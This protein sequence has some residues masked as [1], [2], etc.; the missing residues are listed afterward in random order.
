LDQHPAP[1]TSKAATRPWQGRSW[2]IGQLLFAIVGL[3]LIPFVIFAALA[4]A[5][6]SNRYQAELRRS[7][8]DLSRA[9]AIA[10]HG[11]LEASVH[12]IR[13]Y[14]ES[15]D[16]DAAD[17]RTLYEIA[18]RILLQRPEWS[19]I[20]LADS[21]QNILFSTA[22]PYGEHV[23]TVHQPSL[24]E[25]IRTKQPVV[26]PLTASQTG[27]L[28]VAVRVPLLRAG[29]VVFVLT[30]VVRPAAFLS[31]IH[32]QNVPDS[33]VVTLLDAELGRIAR[34]KDH[35]STLGKPPSASLRDVLVANPGDGVAI[36]KTLENDTVVTGFTRLPTYNWVVVVGASPG[37]FDAMLLR[38]LGY[39]TA[40]GIAAVVVS[41]LLAMGLSNLIARDI[42]RVRKLA[43]EMGHGQQITGRGSVV[44]EVDAIERAI[45]D[46]SVKL[47]TLVEQL[48][49]AAD[50]ARAAGRVKDEFI[51]VTS[52]ELRN[53]LSPIVAA[54]ALLDMKS[55]ASTAKERQILHR[56][57]N[58]LRR[59]VDDLLDVSRLTR[60]EMAITLRLLDLRDVVERV[61]NEARMGLSL[62]QPGVA[63]DFSADDG[64][65]WVMGDDAR[66][67]QAVNNLLG[68]AFRHS[69]GR[70]VSVQVFA[71]DAQ[72]RVAVRDHGTGMDAHTVAQVFA[73]FYQSRD[74]R[75]ALRGSLGLGLAIVKSIVESHGGSVH[76][77][78]EGLGSGSCFEIV[79]QRAPQPAA[80][81]A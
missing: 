64:P 59:L 9:L 17:Y 12:A 33:W 50:E 15:A 68:N 1:A 25:A 62:A 40:G 61:V 42:G 55:D 77:S 29:E 81:A 71:T 22:R 27:E 18:Q 73:P 46:T 47:E 56:Q 75:S 23:P 54:L 74:N 48:R 69:E 70:P 19:T 4:S 45:Q 7:V 67:T 3:G 78:S 2:S 43:T 76:A 60:G 66:L 51:A 53:P 38:G 14:A 28:G 20:T 36:T 6:A 41:I 35:E 57:V 80:P 39:Y 5:D 37:S 10:V 30:V 58:Y 63:I 34:T 49:Q 44:A 31:I 8:L 21:A 16:A 24:Q 65:L 52:H 79:L 26:S 72:V 32:A 11:E 13:V